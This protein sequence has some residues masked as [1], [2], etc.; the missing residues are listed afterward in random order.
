MRPETRVGVLTSPVMGLSRRD[1]LKL[2]GLAGLFP[3]AGCLGRS[4]GEAGEQATMRASDVNPRP[5]IVVIMDDDLNTRSMA[6]LP[7]ITSLLGGTGFSAS[8][9]SYP[10]CGPSRVS[11]WRGQYAHNHGVIDNAT[12][13]EGMR[14]P[15]ADALPVWLKGAGYKT[16][17]IGKYANNC[18]DAAYV[19][20]GWDEFSPMI[21]KERGMAINGKE[22]QISG[23]STELFSSMAQDF[24]KRQ[25]TSGEPWMCWVGVTAPHSPPEVAP[26][27]ADFF[28]DTDLPTPPNFNAYGRNEPDWLAAYPKLP[29]SEIERMTKLYRKQL[30]SMMSVRDLIRDV[31]ATL[32]ETGQEAYIFFTSDNGY[33]M[34]NHR[35][36]EGKVVHFEEDIR[37]PLWVSGPGV[38]EQSRDELILNNDL[39]PTIAD[40]AGAPVPDWVDGR[41][42]AAI[43]R[44]ESPS[45]RRYVGLEGWKQK[46]LQPTIP[47]APSRRGVRDANQKFVKYSTGETEW[48][49]LDSDPRELKNKPRSDNPTG[50]DRLEAAADRIYRSAGAKCRAAEDTP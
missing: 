30:R 24:V 29:D 2:S 9:V 19:P 49:R 7:E 33:H 17:M 43:L 23:N 44:G 39:A 5:N 22:V 45:W 3:A 46:A 50:F 18:Q 11:F 8:F 38:A 16:A 25:G 27:Y 13:C 31:K 21:G 20:P 28:T 36:I 42:Y 35:M 14:G 4:P 15:D 48:Y 47:A 40:L 41:S 12:A 32:A 6:E 1:F 10:L 34:G 37:I 26:E